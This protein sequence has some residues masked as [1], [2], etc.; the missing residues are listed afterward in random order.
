MALCKEM[1]KMTRR[2]LF[3]EAEKMALGGRVR[4]SGG[5]VDRVDQ[6]P[7]PFP[8]NHLTASSYCAAAVMGS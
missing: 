7:Q 5:V 1:G 3:R 4:A 2:P 8:K 6:N